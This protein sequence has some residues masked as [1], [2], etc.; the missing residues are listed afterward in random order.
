MLLDLGLPAMTGTEFLR[1]MRR[2]EVL[3]RIPVIVVTG[4]AKVLSDE[5]KELAAGVLNKPF[6]LSELVNWIHRLMTI[7]AL[8]VLSGVAC[9]AAAFFEEGAARGQAWR[10]LTRDQTTRRP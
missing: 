8:P 7:N 6:N 10:P 4:K 1:H 3:R 5:A 9:P 2:H